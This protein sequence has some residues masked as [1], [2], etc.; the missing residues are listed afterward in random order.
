MSAESTIPTEVQINKEI[1]SFFKNYP[2]GFGNYKEKYAYLNSFI[3]NP[4]FALLYLY[5]KSA[6]TFEGLEDMGTGLSL[7]ES[8]IVYKGSKARDY[9][10]DFEDH[11]V[12]LLKEL[13]V[14][15]HKTPEVLMQFLGEIE[16]EKE[17]D[18]L[19]EELLR[20]RISKRLYEKQSGRLLAT[21]E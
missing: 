18:L 12:I 16:T 21:A 14:M 20:M 13:L 2:K 17:F 1:E 15:A 10:S 19:F 5:Y 8:L 4:P 7:K 11:R 3:D 6:F 9:D